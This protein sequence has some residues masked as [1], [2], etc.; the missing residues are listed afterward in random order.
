MDAYMQRLEA[1][2]QT[3]QD[4]R[5]QQGDEY[6]EQMVAFGDQKADWE[7]QR[8]GAIRG[9]EGMLKS[10]FQDY[11]QAFKGKVGPRWATMGVIMAVLLV[12]IVILQK[13][14]DNV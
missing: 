14:K 9:A 13:R 3:Y 10:V 6:Q 4:L 7:R 2:G 1:Q 5:Q 12:V 11:G 8:E